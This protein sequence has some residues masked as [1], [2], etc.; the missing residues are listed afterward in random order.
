LTSDPHAPDFAPRPLTP[1]QV[2]DWQ[3][4]LRHESDAVLSDLAL[5]VS[6]LPTTQQVAVQALLAARPQIARR[7]DSLAALGHA[8]IT[9][10]RYHGDYH[11]GQVLV[12]EQGFLILDFEGEPLR[13][14]AERR[15]HGS[16]LKDVAGMLRSFS[17][18]AASVL[19]TE[20]S[21]ADVD[22]TEQA[23]WTS[24]WEQCARAAFLDGYASTTRDAPFVP[25]S[26]EMLQAALAVFELEKALYELNYELNNRPDW[27]PI[28]LR[29]IQ[30]TL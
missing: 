17:Y 22:Q 8:G 6:S 16:P 1:E 14:L 25:Q 12:S 11:L 5:R 4:T 21:Q 27:L 7:I 15:A 30:N 26:A 29:G 9:T 24:A 3:A 20:H 28:P 19:V 18:A 10:T 13:S 23:A 2:A